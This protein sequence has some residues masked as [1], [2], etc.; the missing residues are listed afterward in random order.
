MDGAVVVIQAERLASAK[1]LRQKSAWLV[2][3]DWVEGRKYM[4]DEAREEAG[5][6]V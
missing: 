1:A 3:V 2:G 4:E 5:L 6:A